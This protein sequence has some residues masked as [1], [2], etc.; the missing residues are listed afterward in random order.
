M[1]ICYAHRRFD[2]VRL[3]RRKSEGHAAGS[4]GASELHARFQLSSGTS[5]QST[6]P[7]AD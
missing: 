6:Q 1:V 4:H 7:V 5:E 2:C 3:G